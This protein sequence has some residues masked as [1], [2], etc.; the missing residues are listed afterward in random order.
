M[1]TRI[2]HRIM[3]ARMLQLYVFRN[4]LKIFYAKHSLIV[5]SI[6]KFIL[7]LGSLMLINIKLGYQTEI[8]SPAVAV[9]I[10]LVSAFFPYSANV[11]FVAMF[12]M[13]HIFNAS[14][15]LALLIGIMFVL[16]LLIY[17]G[18]NHGDGVLLLL[19]P[20]LFALKIPYVIPLIIGLS[21]S[22]ISII[23]V[24]VGILIYFICLYAK[25]NI[26]TLTKTQ[27]V[28]IAQR[29]SQTINSVF[30]NKTMLLFIIAF[31]LTVL[32][33]YLIHRLSIDYSWQIAIAT[34]A[35]TLLVIVFVGDYILE[36]SVPV[37][38]FILGLLVSMIISYIYNFFVFAVD[39][40]RT[41]YTQFED[42]DYY[43]YVKAVPKITV[44][45]ADKKVQSFT[46]RGRKR[47]KNSGGSE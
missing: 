18:F 36:V 37:L 39:Y 47:A 8:K 44:T 30:S 17:Y 14:F 22:L 45:A 29:Y 24:S 34:G 33:V 31:S 42:D 32:V 1:T 35:I 41:E 23:P 15:E 7:V 4:N 5:D 40:T 38:E 6:I 16:V 11:F 9:A 2:K 21:G 43:Y 28:D 26:G 12:L 3:E 19:V 10:A 20:L 13:A 46:P 27:S 25:Q